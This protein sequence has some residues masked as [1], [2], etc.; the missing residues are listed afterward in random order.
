LRIQGNKDKT[1]NKNDDKGHNI[2]LT[3]VSNDNMN[4]ME[5][6]LLKM[7]R[8]GGEIKTNSTDQSFLEGFKKWDYGDNTYNSVMKRLDYNNADA[9]QD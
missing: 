7:V 2:A 5:L 6:S 9:D 4:N 8:N 1:S 3:D